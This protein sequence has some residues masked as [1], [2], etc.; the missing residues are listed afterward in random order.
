MITA[1]SWLDTGIASDVILLATD[2]S[3]IPQTLRGFSDLGVAVLNSPPFDA[4]R[5]F[6]EGSR[7]FVGGEAAVAM[8]LSNRDRAAPT[9]RC[10]AG[11]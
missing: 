8:V 4:C 3:G 1:K 5:P 9:P 10:W 2:L 11:P 7:G 6:Q